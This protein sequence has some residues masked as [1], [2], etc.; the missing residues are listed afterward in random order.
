MPA[1]WAGAGAGRRPPGPGKQPGSRRR[2]SRRGAERPYFF[3]ALP[4]TPPVRS[5][6]W[7]AGYREPTPVQALC[8]PP[9]LAGKDC[10]G[11]PIPVRAR[12]RRSAC[13]SW[14]GSI[15][16]RAKCRR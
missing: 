10:V 5:A 7:E 3:G 15:P 6:V 11:R 4:L 13:P 9:L 2:R 14:S 8:I 16:R 12:R 1:R